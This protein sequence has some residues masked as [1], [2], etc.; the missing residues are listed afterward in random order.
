MR[1]YS[2]LSLYFLSSLG[3]TFISRYV[4]RNLGTNFCHR[5]HTK[6]FLSLMSFPFLVEQ[7]KLEKETDFFFNGVGPIGGSIREFLTDSFYTCIACLWLCELC[8]GAGARPFIPR[9]S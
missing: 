9:A 2:H 1:I 4:S 7:I 3:F 8:V 5:G 6:D